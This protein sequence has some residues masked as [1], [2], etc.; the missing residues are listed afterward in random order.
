MHCWEGGGGRGCSLL[1][2]NL[3]ETSVANSLPCFMIPGGEGWE[4]I[5]QGEKS[6]LISFSNV[7]KFDDH[8]FS[9]SF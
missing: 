4:D 6:M 7:H 1:R 8:F 2:V 5:Q 9:S 3:L